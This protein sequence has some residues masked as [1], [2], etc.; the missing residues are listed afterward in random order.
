MGNG[1]QP[2]KTE[3]ATSPAQEVEAGSGNVFA[4]PEVPD[5]DVALAK[6]ELA[7]RI[8]AILSARKLTQARGAAVLG[9][10]RKSTRL[11]SSH[12]SISYAVFCLK[13]KK[14]HPEHTRFTASSVLSRRRNTSTPVCT[15]PY[16]RPS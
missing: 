12:V 5:A 1:V 4:D 6:A 10:D 7:R 14:Y 2:K 8:C 11:N 3:R 9:I 13:K 15:R 16:S